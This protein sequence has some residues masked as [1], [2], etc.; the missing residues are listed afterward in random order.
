MG[1]RTRI[2]GKGTVDWPGHDLHGVRVFV[3][4]R[5]PNGE[6]IVKTRTPGAD[7]I[8]VLRKVPADRVKLEP[9]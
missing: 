9:P 2:R 1:T 5:L 8:G 4:Q 3:L 7:T 6:M